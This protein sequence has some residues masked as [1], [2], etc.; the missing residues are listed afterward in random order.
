MRLE[1]MGAAL[2]VENKKRTLVLADL[3]LGIEDELR[4]RGINIGSQTDKVLKRV[5][6]CVRAAEPDA[7]VLLGDIKHAVPGVSYQ[8][9]TEVPR[10]LASL[11]EYAPVY[12]V[13]GNHDSHLEGLMPDET[14]ASI[15]HEI[16]LERTR[17][18]IFDGVGYTHGHTWPSQELFS[19]EYIMIGHN[20][21][22]IRLVSGGAGYT[23]MMSV[24]IRAECSYNAVTQHY[25]DINTDRWNDP[26]VIIMPAFNE[27][28]GG[29]AFN[30]P[31]LKLKGPIASKLILRDTMEAY[32][33]DGTYLGRVVDLD[34]K[35]HPE[36]NEKQ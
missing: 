6:T 3:H 32:L 17:G 14:I 25:K 28:C 22:M 21:P 33:L 9:R 13:K 16:S 27:I 12:V 7:I 10:F 8:D 4:Q 2:I 5:V 31:D 18:F 35:P 11:A 26:W 24:L 34:E 1:M 19:A 29:V 36:N 15:E 23:K 30:S 20:H